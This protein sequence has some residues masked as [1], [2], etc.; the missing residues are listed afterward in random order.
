MDLVVDQSPNLHG[1]VRIPPNKSHS[2]RALI[3]GALAEGKSLVRKPAASNDWML[4]TEAMEMFGASVEPHGEDCWEIVGTGGKLKTPDDIIN[5]GNSGIILRFFT[6]LAA[7]CDGHTVLTG[8]HS[9]RH[10]RPMQPVIDAVNQLGAWA[11]STK[12]DGHAPVVVRGCLRGGRAEIDGA[13]SQPVSALLIAAG[14]ADAPTE[15]IVHNPGEKPWVGV[16]LEWLER[17]GIEYSNE[18]DS[19]THYRIRGKSSWQGFDYT[20][21]LD[22]S[23]A[24]YPIVAALIT[25]DSEVRIAGMDLDDSQGD[26]KVLDVLRQ[27][28]GQIDVDDDG[29]LVARS[30]KLTGQTIDCNDF[31]DQLPL[32]ALVGTVA[33]G[34]TSLTNAAVC[35]GKE[36]DRIAETASSL[37]AMG[38]KITE[39]PDGLVIHQSSLHGARVQSKH[40]HR[41]VFTF[42]LAGLIAQGRTIITDIACIKKTFAH[43]VEEMGSIGC[44]MRKE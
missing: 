18:N 20:V 28:G 11:V 17:C 27:M 34:Q 4:G 7:C 1:S 5:C 38:A 9:L 42:A 31:I 32:L 39:Q 3:M 12:N 6:A 24:L 29:V 41:L 2:F 36:C 40:D 25:P 15:L 19:F 23:A 43:F 8:D 13:D 16:T 14:L 21:P 26:K 30:S 44:D 33:G 10:I 37:S 35:R 22:W